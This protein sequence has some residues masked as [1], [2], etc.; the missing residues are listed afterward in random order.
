[1]DT[2]LRDAYVCLSSNQSPACLPSKPMRGQYLR[3]E[4]V[5]GPHP[6]FSVSCQ[7]TGIIPSFWKIGKVSK[8]SRIE[9]N[10]I[11]E[12]KTRKLMDT[13]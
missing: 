10:S 2:H 9:N 4:I 5:Q 1:M 8:L 3:E 12:N 11:L 6:L 13:H 7:E